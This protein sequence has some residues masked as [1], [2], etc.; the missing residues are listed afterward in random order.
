MGR[1]KP[2]ERDTMLGLSH[3]KPAIENPENYYTDLINE[4]K[5]VLDGITDNNTFE[6]NVRRMFGI[7]AYITFTMDKL[8]IVIARQLQH[9]ISEE[10]NVASMDLYKKFRSDRPLS[11][12]VGEKNEDDIEEAYEEAAQQLMANQNCFKTHFLHKN[13]FVTMELID[14]DITEENDKEE[15]HEHR[16]R[17]VRHFAKVGIDF[18]FFFFENFPRFAYFFLSQTRVFL[19][20]HIF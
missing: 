16:S 7:N 6:D 18:F 12:S 3:L 13:R 14:S 2:I 10:T 19:V 17:Y 1:L 4:I 5:N 9:L 8:I 11:V 15:G 20:L